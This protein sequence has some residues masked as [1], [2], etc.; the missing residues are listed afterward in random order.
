MRKSDFEIWF[1]KT[2]GYPP[3]DDEVSE[4]N[5]N[6]QSAMRAAFEAGQQYTMDA[7][8]DDIRDKKP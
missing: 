3:F 4:E 8:C 1:E 6:V 2:Y 5:M 7:L